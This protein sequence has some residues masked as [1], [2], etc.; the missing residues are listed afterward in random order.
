MLVLLLGFQLLQGHEIM[1]LLLVAGVTADAFFTAVAGNPAIAGV[2][3]IASIPA[4]PGVPISIGVF[5]Y[6]YCTIRQISLADCSF[7]CYRTIGIS[8]NRLV[9]CKNYRISDSQ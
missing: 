2:F 6:W 7:F 3:A 9:N 4:D 8:I 1:L 5:T